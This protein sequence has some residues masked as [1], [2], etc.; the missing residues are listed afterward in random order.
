MEKED[1][2]FSK[3]MPPRTLIGVHFYRIGIVPIAEPYDQ[4][5]FHCKPD[6]DRRCLCVE[7]FR[8]LPSQAS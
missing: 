1:C 4:D 8:A 6:V 3:K 7:L 2:V 5:S